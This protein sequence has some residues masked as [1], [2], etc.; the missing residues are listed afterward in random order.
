[1]RESE[2]AQF[3]SI[4][5]GLAIWAAFLKKLDEDPE[6]VINRWIAEKLPIEEQD[7]DK[8]ND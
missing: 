2:E 6:E 8:D 3:E 7:K 1:M 5:E 4:V